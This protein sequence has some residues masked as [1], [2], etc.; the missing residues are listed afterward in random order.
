MTNQNNV[1]VSKF[2]SKVYLVPII[3]VLFWLFPIIVSFLIIDKNYDIIERIISLSILPLIVSFISL[4][5]LKNNLLN[6]II[7]EETIT[8]RRYL[9]YGK[10]NIY[11]FDDLDGYNIQIKKTK[12]EVYEILK[13]VEDNKTLIQISQFYIDNYSDL[14]LKI[15]QKLKIVNK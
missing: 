7:T 2:N 11:N 10:P 1:T 6:T 5:Q 15:G 12:G 4:Y 13:I 3:I 8:F 9:G 14:K